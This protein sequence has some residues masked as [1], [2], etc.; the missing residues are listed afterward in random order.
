MKKKSTKTKCNYR[1]NILVPLTSQCFGLRRVDLYV[2]GVVKVKRKRVT[3]IKPYPNR[4]DI[5][6]GVM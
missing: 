3:K 5:V 6:L 1:E 4:V 2:W